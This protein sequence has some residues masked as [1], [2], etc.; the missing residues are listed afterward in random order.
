MLI[1]GLILLYVKLIHA[2]T[3]LSLLTLASLSLDQI[4]TTEKNELTILFTSNEVISKKDFCPENFIKGFLALENFLSHKAF[5]NYY[6]ELNELAEKILKTEDKI[7]LVVIKTALFQHFFLVRERIDEA[8]RNNN[9]QLL[10]DIDL[11][12][13]KLH[14]DKLSKVTVVNT[15]NFLEYYYLRLSF[16]PIVTVQHG[17]S[18][19]LSIPYYYPLIINHY[20]PLMKKPRD[21]KRLGDELNRAFEAYLGIFKN[22]PMQFPSFLCS[23]SI[24][25]LYKVTDKNINNLEK[26]FFKNLLENQVNLAPFGPLPYYSDSPDSPSLEYLYATHIEKVLKLIK[27]HELRKR[28]IAL[29]AVVDKIMLLLLNYLVVQLDL[30]GKLFIKFKKLNSNSFHC[31]I[32][33]G[34]KEKL[35]QIEQM[36]YCDFRPIPVTLSSARPM[37][38]EPADLHCKVFLDKEVLLHLEQYKFFQYKF[39][40]DSFDLNGN[41]HLPHQLQKEMSLAKFKELVID[42]VDYFVSVLIASQF[43]LNK[44]MQAI[45][46][47]HLKLSLLFF[48]AEKKPCDDPDHCLLTSSLY[49]RVAIYANLIAKLPIDIAAE[50]YHWIKFELDEFG[51]AE[52]PNFEIY[53][54]GLDMIF[55]SIY[56]GTN[57]PDK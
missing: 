43:S 34:L 27:A 21:K 37:S 5:F 9:M 53:R 36:E 28:E 13:Y 48:F 17:D 1:H 20:I 55:A 29:N 15:F 41:N 49:K 26:G 18:L 40:F 19:K 14:E 22:L 8:M 38:L 44:T 50:C 11:Y 35:S 47:G 33:K 25:K 6:E 10:R 52:Q 32:V 39:Y 42:K 31:R 4:T 16:V 57:L 45:Y 30:I 3:H 24:S 23:F 51:E 2:W 46:I 54:R 56:F 7:T 12:Y